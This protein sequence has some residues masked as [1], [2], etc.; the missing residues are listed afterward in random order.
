MNTEK[1][2]VLGVMSGTSLDGIDCAVVEFTKNKGV[3]SFDFISGK[4]T[5]YSKDWQ[6]KLQHAIHLSDTDLHLLNIEYTYFLAEFLADFITDNNLTDLDFISSHGHTVLHQPENGITLQIGNLP[7]VT[8]MLSLPFVCDFRVQDVKLGGQG[9][10]LVPIGD[11]LLFADYD[12]CLNLG[13]FSNISFEEN[14]ERI[15]FDICPV[16]TL[17]NHFAK[18][19]GKDFDESGNFAAQGTINQDLLNDLN[20]LSFYNQ[21]G[22][23]SLG[24]EQVNAVYLPLIEKYQ[25]TAQ[26]HLATVTEHI[27]YQ[28]ASILKKSNSKL[29]VTG[30]GAFNEHLIN[31]LKFYAPN[32]TVV[33]GSKELI[34]FKEA[35]IFAF[36]GVLRVTNT[37]NVLS[38]VT[39]AS[40]NHCSGTIFNKELLRTNC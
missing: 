40:K 10:P 30:G 27:A 33:L 32:T 5:A 21:Q 36:L 25:L 16:N 4:T 38:S 14:K 11:R 17:L 7:T 22:P 3:W 9:A 6:H 19:L 13:G 20:N 34:E 28:I 12:Y 18:K 15:A 8:D 37:D 29:L 23:K 35:V 2:K 39:G 31:R 24:I 1:F 26:D